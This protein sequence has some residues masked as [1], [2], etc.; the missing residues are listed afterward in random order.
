MPDSVS[1]WRKK[2]RVEKI[3]KDA[4][5]KG[6]TDVVIV[7]EDCKGPS[8]YKKLDTF[9]N[10]PRKMATKYFKLFKLKHNGNKINGNGEWE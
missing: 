10:Q 1:R 6:F 7:N 8:K 5:E 2:A 3:I 9:G 4:I